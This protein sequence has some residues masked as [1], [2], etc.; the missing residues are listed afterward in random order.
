MASEV[1]CRCVAC[2]ECGGA[3]TVWYSFPG[4]GGGEYLGRRRCDDLD[5]LASCPECSGYGLSEVCDHC[6][7]DEEV[8]DDR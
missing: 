6:R 4:E 7:M 1:A 3:G 8:R 2:G 5:E